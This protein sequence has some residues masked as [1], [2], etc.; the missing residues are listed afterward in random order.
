MDTA[1]LG[2]EVFQ[3][4]NLLAVHEYQTPNVDSG[5]NKFEAY[6]LG[7]EW[8]PRP[9]WDFLGLYRKERNS[10]TSNQFSD[11]I[12]LVGHFYL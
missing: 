5:S 7:A 6:S 12:W 1:K 10:A 9:H 8:F 3:G 2:Y 4:L 11:V